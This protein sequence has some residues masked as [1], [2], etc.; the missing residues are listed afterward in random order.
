MM[1]NRTGF[2]DKANVHRRW[3][4]V[5]DCEPLECCGGSP[6]SWKSISDFALPFPS[7]QSNVNYQRL[8]IFTRYFLSIKYIIKS[9]PI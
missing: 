8:K 4:T 9:P 5:I 6:T 7:S 1:S 2:K 3:L